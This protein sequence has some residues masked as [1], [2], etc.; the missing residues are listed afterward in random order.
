MRKKFLNFFL[1]LGS[2]SGGEAARIGLIR[3][4]ILKPKILILDELTS[5]LD[6][7][8]IEKILYFL[9]KYQEKNLISYI[10]IT[11]QE[12]FLRNFKLFKLSLL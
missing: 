4:L 7:I 1:L 10:F 8:H 11:H 3:A 5:S 2:I 6:L 9:K 12:E